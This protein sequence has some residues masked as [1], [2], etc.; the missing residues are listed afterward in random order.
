MYCLWPYIPLIYYN[1]FPCQYVNFYFTIFNGTML[2]HCIEYN[3]FLIIFKLH[4]LLIQANTLSNYHSLSSLCRLQYSFS[5]KHLVCPVISIWISLYSLQYTCTHIIYF[6]WSSLPPSKACILL[7]FSSFYRCTLKSS[8]RLNDVCSTLSPVN[9]KGILGPEMDTLP[10]VGQI[11][12]IGRE[13][14]GPRRVA[15]TCSCLPRHLGIY[16]V[17]WLVSWLSPYDSVCFLRADTC[18]HFSLSL[19]CSHHNINVQYS[20]HVSWVSV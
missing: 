14:V 8:E 10:V 15:L 1:F 18:L 7:L 20:V 5:L 9:V 3:D 4:I 13:E 16:Y 17:Y 2:L 19:P 6:I 11:S 12:I